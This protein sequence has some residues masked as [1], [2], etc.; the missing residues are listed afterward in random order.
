MPSPLKVLTLLCVGAAAAAAVGCSKP[1]RPLA[2]GPGLTADKADGSVE[3]VPKVP[4]NARASSLTPDQR[5]IV[6]ARIGDRLITLGDL[7][8]RLEQEPVVVKSQFASIQK[9]KDYLAKMVQFEVLVLEAQRQGLDKDP[10]VVETLR[11]AMVRRYLQDEV[12]DDDAGKA[13]PD[14]DLKAY[15]DANAQVFHKPDQVELSHILLSDQ[16]KAEEIKKEL[17]R[18]AE[19][20]SAKLIAMWND[21]VVR[22]SEDKVTAPYLGALGLISKVPPQ[23]AE[24]AEIERLAQIPKELVAA[25]FGGELLTVGPVV[26]SDK[27]WHVWMITSKAPAVDKT[28]EDA[29]ESILA[30]IVKRERDLKRQKLLD[31]LRTRAKVTVDDDAV[32]LIGAPKLESALKPATGNIK[33]G[34][35]IAPSAAATAAGAP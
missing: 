6:V 26:H 30:R 16:S 29:K 18:G 9:R 21:Y 33:A 23:G 15:Y 7:E 20:N 35:G 10:E 28:F 24:P 1:E 17:E 13:I 11:Q 4:D 12:K 8:V 32:R 31:D 2:G 3:N 5:S 19:G 25:A 14:A 22:L 34:G 27:G